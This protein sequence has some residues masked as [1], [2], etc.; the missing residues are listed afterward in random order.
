MMV[1][2]RCYPGIAESLGESRSWDRS[3]GE[4]VHTGPYD[5]L[6]ILIFSHDPAKARAM[7]LPGDVEDAWD[8]MQRNLLN[9]STRSRRIIAQGSGHY[10]QLDRP[11]LIEQQVTLFIKQIRGSAPPPTDYGSTITE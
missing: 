6:P 11:K 3:G 7:H 10:I 4:T 9:L 5:A 1:E 8:R 2:D